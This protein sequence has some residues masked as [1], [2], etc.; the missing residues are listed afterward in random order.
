M[1]APEFQITNESTV[2]GYVNFMQNTISRG[3]GDVKADYTAL[4]PLADTAQVLLDELNLVLA[5][6]QL[7]AATMTLIATAVDTMPK[8]TDPARLNRIYAALVMV[9]ASPEFIVQK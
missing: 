8:G 4:L 6:D 5:A 7:T 1:V 3:I 9:M 2:V